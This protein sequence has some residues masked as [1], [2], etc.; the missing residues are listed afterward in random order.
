MLTVRKDNHGAVRLYNQYGFEIVGHLQ[1][2]S[3][4]VMKRQPIR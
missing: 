3:G 2:D 4:W 1:G